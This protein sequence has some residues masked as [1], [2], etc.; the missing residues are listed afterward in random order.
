MRKRRKRI[1]KSA[2]GTAVGAM[3]RVWQLD[4]KE[5]LEMRGSC[6]RAI[7]VRKKN[8]DHLTQEKLQQKANDV[9]CRG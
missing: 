7:R 4:S 5:S 3:S 9:L 8:T 6:P 2:K 1:R